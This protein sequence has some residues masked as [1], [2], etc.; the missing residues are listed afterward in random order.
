MS[1][2]VGGGFGTRIYFIPNAG[3][4]PKS[5][6]V[7]KGS[8][9]VTINLKGA[10]YRSDGNLW[11]QIFGGSDKVTLSTQ[12]SHVS[13]SN[14]TVSS[15]S[16]EDMREISVGKP[17]YFGSN[18]AVALD[19]PTDCDE[20]SMAVTMSAVKSDNLSGALDILNSGELK[21]T[22]QLAPPAVSGALAIAN[23]VKKLLTNTDPQSSLQGEYDGRMSLSASDNP[24]R[25]YCLV[26]G[27]IILIYRES[28]DD[29]S[30]DDLD[31]TKLS[32]DGDGLKYDGQVLQNT[33]TM[34]QVSFAPLRGEDPSA[35]WYGI[36]SAAEQS[37]GG[38]VTAANDAD[39]Q[40]IWAAAFATYQQG[41]KLLL[42]DPTYTQYE[43]KGLAA[44]HLTS[45]QQ[46]Y[47][48]LTGQ[49]KPLS[50]KTLLLREPLIQDALSSDDIE[51]V[52]QDYRARL[53]R[54]NV[55]LPGPLRK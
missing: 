36:F 19:L 43:A 38:L 24:V 15:S 21:G 47:A 31:P 33:Y 23:V 41:L 4:D 42:A 26:Q 13:Q 51:K 22:L 11:Q 28:E 39:K 12:M 5:S 44:T 34:F 8:G 49:P 2:S 16:I 53:A 46:M 14:G 18:R 40:K 54:A 52:A 29:T 9:Y 30:L 27:T 25:D 1:G 32:T 50:A 17:Y 45:L 37:L 3:M 55:S 20:I 7:L 35:T 6:Q 48:T 10:H